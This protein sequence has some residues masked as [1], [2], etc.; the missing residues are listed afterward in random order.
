[1]RVQSSGH[2][3]HSILTHW[4]QPVAMQTCVNERFVANARA[5]AAAPSF[6]IELPDNPR[7]LSVRLAMSAPANIAAPA[8]PIPLLTR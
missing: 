4:G 1:M 8:A 3:H 2:P 5:I 6:P 7:T